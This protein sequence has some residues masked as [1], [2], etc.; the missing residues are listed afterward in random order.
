M[1]C[2][3]PLARRPQRPDAEAPVPNIQIEELKHLEQCERA[4]ANAYR[5]HAPLP[6]LPEDELLAIARQHLEHA[7]ILRGRIVALGGEPGSAADYSWVT[8]RDLHGLIVAERRALAT[9][10]DHLTDLDPA[11][12]RMVE[13][14][15]L[16][17]HVASA[18]RI[19]AGY[20]PGRNGEITDVR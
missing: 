9:Y 10:H 13:E 12:A 17:D 4:L 6:E 15:I 20:Q 3:R 7:A 19:D 5:F 14:H 11:S 18:S 1:D 8:G 16:H 2:S